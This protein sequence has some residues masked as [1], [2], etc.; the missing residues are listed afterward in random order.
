MTTPTTDDALR[1]VIEAL[2]KAFAAHVADDTNLLAGHSMF[3]VA[4]YAT[5]IHR[6]LHTLARVE[7]AVV[8]EVVEC[9]DGETKQTIG[10]VD[11]S[12]DM[13]GKRVRLV[14]EGEG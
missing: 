3:L 12:E 14:L 13:I 8:V 9:W 11:M 7:A 4:N 5:T 10:Q 1:E 6:A 2:D